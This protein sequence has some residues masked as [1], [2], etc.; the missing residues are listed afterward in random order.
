MSIVELL[1]LGGV[2]VIGFRICPSTIFLQSSK[3]PAGI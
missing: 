2:L 1:P 3:N